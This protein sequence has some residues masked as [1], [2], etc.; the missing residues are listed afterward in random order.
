MG[1]HPRPYIHR[2][3]KC[4]CSFVHFSTFMILQN[5][6]FLLL[7]DIILVLDILLYRSRL[8]TDGSGELPNA[9]NP[10]LMSVQDKLLH[11]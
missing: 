7:A 2:T 1:G 9:Q 10:N 11:T 3:S 6:V 5:N 4:Q 8:P